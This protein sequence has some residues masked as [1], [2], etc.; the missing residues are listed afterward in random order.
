MLYYIYTYIYRYVWTHWIASMLHVQMLFSRVRSWA[1]SIQNAK[2]VLSQQHFYWI[3]FWHRKPGTHSILHH[4]RT[5][6]HTLWI[7]NSFIGLAR[8]YFGFTTNMK[9]GECREICI[10]CFTHTPRIEY[11]CSELRESKKF[12]FVPTPTF[13]KCECLVA[14]G[15]CHPMKNNLEPSKQ[16]RWQDPTCV[17]GKLTTKTYFFLV[18]ISMSFTDVFYNGL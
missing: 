9:M 5:D 12:R 13:L 17:S 15:P 11:T 4:A 10:L 7:P 8:S 16:T 2:I 6:C 18:R 3:W 14:S 1:F